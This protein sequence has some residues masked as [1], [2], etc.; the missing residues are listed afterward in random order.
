MSRIP[1][2]DRVQEFSPEGVYITQF[3]ASRASAIAVDSEGN[4]W[5]DQISLPGVI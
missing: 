3:A 1:R 5:V 4:V 2:N